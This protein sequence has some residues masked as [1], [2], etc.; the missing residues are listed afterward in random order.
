[1]DEREYEVKMMDD[2]GKYLVIRYGAAVFL[3]KEKLTGYELKYLA[4]RLEHEA[5]ETEA[6]RKALMK[7][8]RDKHDPKRAP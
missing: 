6:E 4:E 1:M 2:E 7:Y 3:P 8:Y 5:Q